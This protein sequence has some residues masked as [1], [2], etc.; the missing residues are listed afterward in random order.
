[1]RPAQTDQIQEALTRLAQGQRAA[2]DVV[3]E[4]LWPLVRATCL[5]QLHHEAEAEDAAQ[6][7]MMTLFEQA[8][9]FDP[10]RSA[11]AWALTLAIWECR[12]TRR[13]WSRSRQEPLHFAE[14]FTDPQAVCP[15]LRIEQRQQWALVEAAIAQMSPIDR[16]TVEA[17]LSEQAPPV[18]DATFRKRRQR[19][20]ARLLT[21]LGGLRA[22]SKP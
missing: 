5:R 21:N 8:A 4:G 18:P 12:T 14:T 16:Q 2:F 1:M 7:A 9:D 20:L 3:F 10:Q 15:D 19:M 11:V 22:E 6:R 17:M 13:R